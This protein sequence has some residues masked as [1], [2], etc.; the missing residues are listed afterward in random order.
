MAKKGVKI[1]ITYLIALIATFFIF[2]FIGWVYIDMLMGTDEPTEEDSDT[3]IGEYIPTAADNRTVLAVV[4]YGSEKTDV[5]FMLIRFL[6]GQSEA[7]FFPVPADTLVTDDASGSVGGEGSILEGVPPSGAPSSGASSS[8]E[9]PSGDSTSGEST[10]GTETTLFSAYRSGSVTA[11]SAAVKSTMGITVDKY[12]V[13]DAESFAHFCDV[14]GSTRYVIPQDLVTRDNTVIVAGE[15]YL[16][17]NTMRVLLTYQSY[18][19]SE[20]ERARRF[21]EIVTAMLNT[22]LTAP[23][24][25]LM[26]GAFADI[27]NSGADTDISRFDY[28]ESYDPLRYTLEHTDR[29]CRYVLSSGTRS[30][31][32]NY[33]LDPESVTAV[34]TW[35]DLA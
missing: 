23:F 25:S 2:G 34:K 20:E 17:N 15:T 33:R 14:F 11:V 6:P 21:A 4:D 1:G 27:V 28:E 24:V 18:K 12:I 35:F 29:F 16:D 3:S 7:V 26:D 13:F 32:G 10:S 19:G 30:E 22:Q 5:C 31:G 8:D 9:S